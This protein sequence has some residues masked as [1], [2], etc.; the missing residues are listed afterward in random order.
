MD[1][2]I[3]G[4]RIETVGV[5]F[6]RRKLIMRRVHDVGPLSCG[7][8]GEFAVAVVARNGLRHKGGCAVVNISSAQLAC[9]GQ[10]GIGLD[11]RGGAAAGDHS[12]IVGA[13]DVHRDR[14]TAGTVNAFHGDAVAD[15]LTSFQ[16]V[17]GTI[18][19]VGPSAICVHFESAI[20]AS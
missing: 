14:A 18:A 5:A 4:G 10:D 9:G 13:C 8:N 11:Q 3:G 16:L 15:H 6:T 7:V 19:C 1:S 12:C 17:M 20:R 2:A